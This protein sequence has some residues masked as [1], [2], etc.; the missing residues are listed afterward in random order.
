MDWKRGDLLLLVE[1]EKLEDYLLCLVFREISDNIGLLDFLFL[2]ISVGV[3]FVY[4]RS[5]I[6]WMLD[7]GN[8]ML[9]YI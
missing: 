9:R 1:K 3:L 4:L 8:F 6:M 5:F 2:L 7:W